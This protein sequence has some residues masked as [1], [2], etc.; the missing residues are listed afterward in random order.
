MRPREWSCL[1]EG[2]KATPVHRLQVRGEARLPG[3]QAFAL[4]PLCCSSCSE[5]E[6]TRC[7]R[8]SLRL[9][10]LWFEFSHLQLVAETPVERSVTFSSRDTQVLP[11]TRLPLSLE[12]YLAL[13]HIACECSKGNTP[14]FSTQAGP[15]LRLL[16]ALILNPLCL[17]R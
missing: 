5:Y 7:S 12:S 10:E 9:P 4:S 14:R 8:K 15:L 13:R 11:L 16:V 2:Q 3:E 6:V 17:D 1:R